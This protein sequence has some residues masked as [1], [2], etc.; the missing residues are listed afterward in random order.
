MTSTRLALVFA[1]L[2]P[3][4]ALAGPSRFESC[5]FVDGDH[6]NMSGELGDAELARK[7][8][9]GASRVFWFKR[10]GRAYVIT[11][12]ATLDRIKEAYRPVEELGEW[13]GELGAKQGEI[14]AKQGEL[15]AAQAKLAQKTAKISRLRA[16][17]IDVSVDTTD[18]SIADLSDEMSSLGE[19]MEK[20][21]AKMNKLGKKMKAA[22]AKAD[23]EVAAIVAEAE[24]AGL[25]KPVPSL[26][27]A[28]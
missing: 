9:G 23:A 22:S 15:G 18:E 6:V 12:A 25:V 17:G 1:A 4:V 2:S 20:M 8:A 27:S 13:M 7:A 5:A 28:P 14:G 10:D 3:L 19:V 11:D 26:R 21:G 16:K 24:K